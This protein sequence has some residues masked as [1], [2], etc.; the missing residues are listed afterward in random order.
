MG[1]ASGGDIFDKVTHALIDSNATNKVLD[2]VCYELATALRD[3]DWDT[4]DES[5]DEFR[6]NPAVVAAL[7]R[8]SGW[9]YLN[10]EDDA[11]LDYHP[12]S[13]EWSI[14][15]AGRELGRTAGTQEGPDQLVRLWFADGDDTP[16]RREQMQRF[17]LDPG[18]T[19]Q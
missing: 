4:I 7:R 2:H 9:T 14:T 12:G 18:A 17:L 6:D 1:W 16:D 5:V 11:I 19:T 10:G 15:V 13:D 3:G 8:A